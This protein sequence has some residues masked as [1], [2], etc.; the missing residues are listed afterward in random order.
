M[1]AGTLRERVTLQKRSV[2][3]NDGYGNTLSDFADQFSVDARIA[4]LKGGETVLA[5]RLTGTQPVVVTVRRSSSTV[6]IDTDWRLVDARAGTIYN[7][8]AV[9]PDEKKR[10]IDLL[11]EAG[12]AS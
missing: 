3:A 2:Q 12:V 9:T 11:C 1:R 4:P 6:L 10:H 8:R 5:A 7:I